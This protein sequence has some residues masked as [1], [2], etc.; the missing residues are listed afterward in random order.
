MIRQLKIAAL[1]CIVIV[2]VALC[3]LF[4][5]ARIAESTRLPRSSPTLS[6]CQAK[7]VC[8]GLMMANVRDYHAFR[9]IL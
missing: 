7:T 8:A 1:T 6:L 5:L 9:L 3:R 2:P 4:G